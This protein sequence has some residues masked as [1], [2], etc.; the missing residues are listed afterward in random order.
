[1][2]ITNVIIIIRRFTYDSEYCDFS[3]AHCYKFCLIVKN[4]NCIYFAECTF[5]LRESNLKAI[6]GYGV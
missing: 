5:N 2:I 6:K 3:E 1:M 4:F